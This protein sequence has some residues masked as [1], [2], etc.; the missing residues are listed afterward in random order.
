M[1]KRSIA[2]LIIGVLIFMLSL[3]V[4]AA[5]QQKFSFR[6]TTADFFGED[7][8]DKKNYSI[9]D[10]YLHVLESSLDDEDYKKVLVGEVQ[11]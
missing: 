5:V 1:K 9:D 8:T 4:S 2:S 10:P 3:R 11:V 6:N 7:Y